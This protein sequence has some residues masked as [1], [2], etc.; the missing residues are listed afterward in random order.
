MAKKN[1]TIQLSEFENYDTTTCPAFSLGNASNGSTTTNPDLGSSGGG[2]GGNIAGSGG[3]LS[4]PINVN[5]SSGSSYY[6]KSFHFTPPILSD[7]NNKGLKVDL[8]SAS[9]SQFDGGNGS[10]QIEES[11]NSRFDPSELTTFV[12]VGEHTHEV[13]LNQAIRIAGS[14][15][16]YVRYVLVGGGGGGGGAG[17][18][19]GTNGASGTKMTG[20]VFIVK[21][22]TTLK[23][24]VGGGGKAGKTKCTRILSNLD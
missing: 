17:L 21:R 20:G 8:T 18:N 16:V 6:D 10:V 4:N 24:H 19:K 15:D 22:G 7:G 14:D 5:G 12:N 1:C 13:E 23:I 3:N 11:P 2:G 9:S